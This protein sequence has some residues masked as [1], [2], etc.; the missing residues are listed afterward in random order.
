MHSRLS[1]SLVTVSH[2]K[3]MGEKKKKKKKTHQNL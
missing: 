1:A 2:D 3:V